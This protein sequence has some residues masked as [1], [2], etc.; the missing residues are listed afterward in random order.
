MFLHDYANAI[1][2]LK[3]RE[4]FHLFTLVIFLCQKVLITLQRMQASFIFSQAVVV[5]L[6]TSQLPPFQNTL[7]ITM[8]N[9]L[10]AINFLHINMADLS[11]VVNYGHGEI[12]TPT[13]S[14]LDVLSLLP[15]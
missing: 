8:V 1:W 14:Q 15:F 13:L 9:L 4:N 11:Q 5:S 7:P 3:G 10:H 6:V 12:F 2:S